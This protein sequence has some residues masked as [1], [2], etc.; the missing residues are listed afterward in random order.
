[1]KF[2]RTYTVHSSVICDL[3]VRAEVGGATVDAIVAGRVV[4]LT[5]D[6]LP[7][8]TQHLL[9]P[10][11]DDLAELFAVGASVTVTFTAPKA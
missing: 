5:A 10:M 11:A 3:S 2:S 9:P 8:I 7:S 4:E 6:G 1:M